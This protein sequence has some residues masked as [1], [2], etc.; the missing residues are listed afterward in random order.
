MLLYLLCA[1]LSYMLFK[2]M[3]IKY[4][5]FSSRKFILILTT[6]VNSSILV[7]H[8][9][10]RHILL[11]LLYLL[12]TLIFAKSTEDELNWDD[13]FLTEKVHLLSKLI[14]TSHESED[15]LSRKSPIIESK[16]DDSLFL[17]S[18]YILPV[19]IHSAIQFYCGQSSQIPDD[20]KSLF[21]LRSLLTLGNTDQT[22][23]DCVTDKLS[24]YESYYETDPYQK[25]SSNLHNIGIY[26][27]KKLF[28]EECFHD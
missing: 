23:V 5:F 1:F 15:S 11:I 20:E 22:V 12:E 2:I 6:L 19:E 10:T 17:S 27:Y 7:N 8:K 26:E 25:S 28:T 24:Q 4:F 14:M 16:E 13:S 18:K 9:I 21:F 3:I